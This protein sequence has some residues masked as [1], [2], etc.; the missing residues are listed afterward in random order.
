MDCLVRNNGFQGPTSKM[1]VTL[2][3]RL[4]VLVFV[5]ELVNAA[6]TEC[7]QTLVDSVRITEEPSAKWTLQ[8]RVEISLLYPS[9]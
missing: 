6:L 3:A 1:R 4:S 9:D 8:K 2:R 5:E 7:V